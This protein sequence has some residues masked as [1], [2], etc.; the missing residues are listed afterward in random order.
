MLVVPER[1][2]E[3]DEEERAGVERETLVRDGLFKDRDE[4]ELLEGATRLEEDD[5]ERGGVDLILLEERL[6]VEKE[7]CL[8]GDVKVDFG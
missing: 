3:R 8:I 7:P 4:E 5:I 1:E 6:G 2:E